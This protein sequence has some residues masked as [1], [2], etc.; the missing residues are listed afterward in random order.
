MIGKETLERLMRSAETLS[1]ALPV[2]ERLLHY[3]PSQG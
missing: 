3:I 2:A 1:C